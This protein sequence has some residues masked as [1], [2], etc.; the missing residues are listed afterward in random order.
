MSKKKKKKKKKK[1][2]R[3]HDLD[4]ADTKSKFSV[5]VYIE[6]HFKYLTVE[7]LIRK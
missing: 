2:F 7:V 5:S 6:F 3:L 1:T 4:H